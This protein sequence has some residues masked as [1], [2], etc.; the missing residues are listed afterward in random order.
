M[1]TGRFLVLSRAMA[2]TRDNR[3]PR[4]GLSL[5]AQAARIARLS[6]RR[7]E[8]IRPALESPHE[9]ILLTV[10]DM[11]ERLGTDPATTVRIFRG[12]GFGTYKEF[13]RYLHELSLA[14]ATSL[15]VLQSSAV[16]EASLSS[17]LRNA[18]HQD[19][20][21]V[22]ALNSSLDL[23]R[24]IGVAKRLWQARRILLLGGDLA[25]SLVSYLHYNLSLLGMEVT[26]ATTPGIAIH[27]VRRFRKKDVVIGMSFRRGLRLTVEGMQQARR[28]GAYCVGITDTYISP[29]ARSAH[30]FFL[31]S[32]KT[33]FGA[34]YAAPMA[35]LNALLVA[36]A[37]VN[38]HRTLQMI[39]LA[40]EEQR[41]GFRWYVD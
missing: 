22:R 38:R 11:A 18:L 15:D 8:L 21:N 10:R 26:M 27:T 7:K 3:A 12:L 16:R 36:C 17:L 14:N 32:V 24:L 29:I 4:N 13:Q 5:K 28:Q 39:K 6:P 25:T 1:F 35:V 19:L 23:D 37:N 33:S 41:H 2:S 30:E 34:S 40:D 9:F 20:D 31:A